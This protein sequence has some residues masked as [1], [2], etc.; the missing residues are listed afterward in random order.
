MFNQVCVERL[1]KA[2]QIAER[3]KRFF[4]PVFHSRISPPMAKNLISCS[5]VPSAKGQTE[6]ENF[7]RLVRQNKF[8][9]RCMNVKN[10]FYVKNFSP[11]T[12]SDRVDWT[13][14]LVDEISRHMIEL[15]ISRDPNR[16]M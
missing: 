6:D 1:S 8:L 10:D 16:A 4:K 14:L 3:I 11:D 7:Q 2:K 9:Q 13:L 15:T 12:E 5:F